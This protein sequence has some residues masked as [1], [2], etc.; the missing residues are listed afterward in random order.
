MRHMTRWKGWYQPFQRVEKLEGALCFFAWNRRLYTITLSTQR[1]LDRLLCLCRGRLVIGR[2][3]G[4]LARFEANRLEN[5]SQHDRQHEI[6]D[7]CSQCYV[8]R[9]SY[10]TNRKGVRL[11]EGC[12]RYACY[13]GRKSHQGTADHPRLRLLAL[14]TVG[15]EVLL[16]DV[17]RKEVGSSYRHYRGGN[18]CSDG[19]SGESIAC[20]PVGEELR[21]Q[22]RYCAIACSGGLRQSQRH[23]AKQRQ[24]TEHQ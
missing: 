11:Q 5:G 21:D 19:D 24:Q 13:N 17:A 14:R 20:Q 3:R 4:I 2:S 23:K 6:Q 9:N 12:S 15:A 8:D 7:Q 18:Q 1:F 10:S 22:C 16:V